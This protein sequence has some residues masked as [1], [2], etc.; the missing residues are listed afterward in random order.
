MV[1]GGGGD[2]SVQQCHITFLTYDDKQTELLY[3]VKKFTLK[4]AF[5]V[6]A[7]W[8]FRSTL[9]YYS[10]VQQQSWKLIRKLW[11]IRGY[12]RSWA[13]GIKDSNLK[14]QGPLDLFAGPTQSGRRICCIKYLSCQKNLLFYR[15]LQSSKTTGKYLYT[16][17]HFLPRRST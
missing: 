11:H 9:S 14:W 15:F 10:L 12:V 3:N 13:F 17:D 4:N 5:F 8:G 6:Y 16:L 1:G 7:V 2:C